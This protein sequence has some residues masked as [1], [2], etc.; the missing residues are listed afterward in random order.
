M[1][2]IRTGGGYFRE[3]Y[4]FICDTVFNLVVQQGVHPTI[5]GEV[6]EFLLGCYDP[7]S[8][9]EQRNHLR[10]QRRFSLQLHFSLV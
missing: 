3:Y 9:T 2:F 7:K 5:K 1:V 10:Q 8:T 6:W 4:S